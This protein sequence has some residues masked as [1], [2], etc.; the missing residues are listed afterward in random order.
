MLSP[1]EKQLVAALLEEDLDAD[2]LTDRL[3][4]SPQ[5]ATSLL[6]MLELRGIV[7]RAEGKIFAVNRKKITRV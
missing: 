5:E 6:T 4:I 7:Y 2:E 1:Q 3:K